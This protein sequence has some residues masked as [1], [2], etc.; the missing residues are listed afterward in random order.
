MENTIN[1]RD[2]VDTPEEP[3]ENRMKAEPVEVEYIEEPE[4]ENQTCIV[5]EIFDEPKVS[6]L[7][8][9]YIVESK[10]GATIRIRNDR[11]TI[12]VL[13]SNTEPINR[14]ASEMLDE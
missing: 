6:F 5:D 10:V 13:A 2:W 1:W 9:E 14:A 3:S 11:E 4:E 12:C 8:K 7:G